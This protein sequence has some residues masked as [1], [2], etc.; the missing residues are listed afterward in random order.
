MRSPS[1]SGNCR[2]EV[3]GAV[4]APC[5]LKLFTFNDHRV[6]EIVNP[7]RTEVTARA[8]VHPAQAGRVMR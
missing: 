5:K 3:T 1:D 8:E 2:S 4:L 7:Y 6:L